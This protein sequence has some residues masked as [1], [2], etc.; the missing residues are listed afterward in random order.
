VSTHTW[1]WL[2]S[3]EVKQNITVT[4]TKIYFCPDGN[5]NAIVV[6]NQGRA[7]ARRNE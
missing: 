4:D 3:F 6:W 7:Y 2:L 5:G 1:D